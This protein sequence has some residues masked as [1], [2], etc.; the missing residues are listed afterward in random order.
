MPLRAIVIDFVG[1][2]LCGLD[3]AWGRIAFALSEGNIEL[4]RIPNKGKKRGDSGYF[5]SVNFTDSEISRERIRAKY[6]PDG[7]PAAFQVNERFPVG[8]YPE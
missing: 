7:Y 8:K 4:A 2:D 6:I 5:S 1:Q 3:I